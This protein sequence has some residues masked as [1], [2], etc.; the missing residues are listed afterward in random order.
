[1]LGRGKLEILKWIFSGQEIFDRTLIEHQETPLN[2]HADEY[3]FK[4]LGLVWNS[5]ADMFIFYVLPFP[6]QSPK[7]TFYSILPNYMIL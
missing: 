7:R 2:V 5:T 6:D 4:I 1:M 3:Y